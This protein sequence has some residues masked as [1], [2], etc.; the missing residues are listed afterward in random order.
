MPPVTL[1]LTGGIDRQAVAPVNEPL[2]Y[3]MVSG[4][5]VVSPCFWKGTVTIALELTEDSGEKHTFDVEWS[6][7]LLTHAMGLR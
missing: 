2:P 3:G 4:Q 5:W 1:T 7:D 6:T